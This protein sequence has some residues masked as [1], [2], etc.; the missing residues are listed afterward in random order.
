MSTAEAPFIAC[1]PAW[2][3]SERLIAGGVARRDRTAGLGRRLRGRRDR[4]GGLCDLHELRDVLRADTRAPRPVLHRRLADDRE[5]RRNRR[6]ARRVAPVP[7]TDDL[8]RP[9]AG[10]RDLDDVGELPAPLD[11]Q[12]VAEMPVLNDGLLV[13]RDD[14]GARERR[15]VGCNRAVE[16]LDADGVGRGEL[17]DVDVL[18]RPLLEHACACD[19]AELDDRLVDRDARGRVGDDDERPL[20]QLTGAIVSVASPSSCAA[21]AEASTTWTVVA[22]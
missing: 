22:I 7:I 2:S 19:V 12:P 6:R 13:V 15:A 21:T 20:A 11:E 17:R 1:V 10:V 18:T 14:E 9:R 5:I 8:A 16:C 3:E 4:A